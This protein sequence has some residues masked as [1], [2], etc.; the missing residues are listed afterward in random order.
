M[1]Q[2]SFTA[3]F[4]DDKGQRLDYIFIHKTSVTGNE[5]LTPQPERA[6]GTNFPVEFLTEICDRL[7]T[8]AF[9]TFHSLFFFFLSF[10]LLDSDHFSR[11]LRRKPM[12]YPV[13]CFLNS[14]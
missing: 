3:F 10:F 1:G 4:V 2:K 11:L 14:Y 13:I 12:V 7:T 6:G 8:R 9:L 5:V